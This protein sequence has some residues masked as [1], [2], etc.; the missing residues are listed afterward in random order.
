MTPKLPW[1]IAG[2]AGVAAVG[3][4]VTTRAGGRVEHPEPRPAVTAERVLPAS[5]VLNTPG[6]A[7]AYAA[8]RQAPQVLDGVHC[9]CECAKHLGH[10]SLLTC[11]E[12]DHGAQCDICMGEAVLAARDRKSVV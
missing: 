1:I 12:T 7:E 8:A 5:T 3:L 2:V 11:F 6:A 10:R 9:Y 4:L